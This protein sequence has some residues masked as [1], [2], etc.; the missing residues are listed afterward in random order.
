MNE[1]GTLYNCSCLVIGFMSGKTTRQ[2]SKR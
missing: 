2:N 1:A